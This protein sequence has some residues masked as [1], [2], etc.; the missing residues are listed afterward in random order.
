MTMRLASRIPTVFSAGQETLGRQSEGIIGAD[1][2][3]EGPRRQWPWVIRHHLS[4]PST[5]VQAIAAV[6]AQ[7]VIHRVTGKARMIRIT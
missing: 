5:Y 2:V 1:A 7:P 4:A 6:C 3:A